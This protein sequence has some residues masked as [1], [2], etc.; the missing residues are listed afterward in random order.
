M[1]RACVIVSDFVILNVLLILFMNIEGDTS[2]L[3][4][5]SK[6]FFV[7]ANFSMIISEFFFSTIIFQRLVA[8]PAIA[9]NTFK[10]SLLQ[11]VISILD[12]EALDIH[13]GNS[14]PNL[15]IFFICFYLI[16]LLSRMAEFSILKRMRRLGHNVRRVIL[17]GNDPALRDL[18]QTL[19]SDLSFGYIV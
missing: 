13:I 10:L 3:N 19:I 17:V 1:A 2:V 9:A 6:V 15:L 12:L 11:T 8:A 16:L 18:Y 5:H 7:L 14:A 4:L